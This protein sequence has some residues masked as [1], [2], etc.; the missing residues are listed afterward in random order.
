[1][2]TMWLVLLS[3]MVWLIMCFMI[4]LYRALWVALLTGA[5]ATLVYALSFSINFVGVAIGLLLAAAFPMLRDV[6]LSKVQDLRK[7]IEYKD[8]G[9]CLAFEEKQKLRELEDMGFWGWL[10][11]P[12]RKGH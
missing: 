6:Y 2:M 3:G 11:K 10:K 1:M 9:A 4:G 8:V 12:F 7:D 5:L